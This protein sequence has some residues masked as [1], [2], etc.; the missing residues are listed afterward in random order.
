MP[1]TASSPRP[2]A[3]LAIQKL[4]V[5]INGQSILRDVDLE[6][7]PGEIVTLIGPNG[8]GKSTLLRASLGLIRPTSGQVS[9]HP[10]LTVGYVPQNLRVNPALP[11][12][13]ADFIRLSQPRKGADHSPETLLT[14]LG[15]QNLLSKPMAALSG[16]ETQ[17][18]LLARALI[19]GPNLL[20][21]DEP[22]QG[23]D[24]AGEH[25]LHNF[26]EHLCRDR[27]MGL[28]LV[29]HDL[30]FV[31]AATHRVICL[32]R[33]VCCSGTPTTVRSNP[34]FHTLFGEQVSGFGL[35]QHHH[36]HKHSLHGLEKGDP[37]HG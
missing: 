6:V 17:R 34:A 36:D 3:L 33:H 8:A 25:A 37:H 26:L 24:V 23:M 18:V 27:A 7:Y 5:Q 4:T 2:P 9:R 22:A 10:D 21:L 20:V 32:N 28:L 16:G 11:L 12:T 15:C 30:H 14:Q 29:S 31:M 13:A 35:Y 1:P 19:R